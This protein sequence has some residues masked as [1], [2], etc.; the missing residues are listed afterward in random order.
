MRHSREGGNPV[1]LHPPKLDS[2]LHGNDELSASQSRRPW[3]AVWKSLQISSW[4]SNH[5]TIQSVAWFNALTPNPLPEGEGGE[6]DGFYNSL[7]LR[8]RDTGWGYSWCDSVL[9]QV[10]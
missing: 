6:L 2:R 8:E 1:R 10:L 3:A 9:V 4:G 7:S 5:A